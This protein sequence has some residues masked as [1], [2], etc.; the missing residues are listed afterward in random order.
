VTAFERSFRVSYLLE[1]VV[2]IHPVI[3]TR[4]PKSDQTDG[5]SVSLVAT[6]KNLQGRVGHTWQSET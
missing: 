5:D 1:G 6:I 4:A 2:R 3:R